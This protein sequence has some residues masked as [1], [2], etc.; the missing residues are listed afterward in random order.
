MRL[1]VTLNN[2]ERAAMWL[3]GNKDPAWLKDISDGWGR[4]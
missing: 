4:Y 2:A 3:F 1:S